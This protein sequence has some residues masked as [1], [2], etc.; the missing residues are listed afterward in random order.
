M[1]VRRANPDFFTRRN[2]ILIGDTLCQA[3]GNLQLLDNPFKEYVIVHRVDTPEQY[4]RNC[5]RWSH[6]AAN[7]DTFAN[8]TKE[9]NL[10][11][12]TQEQCIRHLYA[13]MQIFLLRS[14][15]S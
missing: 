7:D 5:D 6:T 12:T 10:L 2:N 15:P 14:K 8:A 4:D 11:S 9:I 13:D 3:Y 1:A